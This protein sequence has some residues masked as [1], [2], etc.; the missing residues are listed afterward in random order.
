[1]GI[2]RVLLAIS[3]L[4][5]HSDSIFGVTL[6]NGDM[7]VTC[8][9]M[10]SGFLMALI[11]EQKYGSRSLFYLNRA[12][13]IYP[14]YLA[15]L[16]VSIMVFA[17]IHS[18]RHDPF[19]FVTELWTTGAH[20]GVFIA[21]L[22]NLTLIGADLTRYLSFHHGAVQFPSFLYTVGAGA[23]NLLFV[24]QCWTLAIELE[25][26]LLAPFIVRMSTARIAA[27]ALLSMA[28]RHFAL[29][30]F[31]SNGIRFDGG[32]FFP[33]VL[34]YFLLGVLAYRIYQIYDELPLGRR[35]RIGLEY[36]SVV[37]AILLTYFGRHIRHVVIGGYET[38]YLL[39][40]LQLP[41]LF[42]F[43]KNR[44]W[45]KWLGEYSYPIYLMHFVVAQLLYWSLVANAW[46]GELTLFGTLLLSAAYIYL[47]DRPIQR[48][49]ARIASDAAGTSLSLAKRPIVG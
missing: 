31:H 16:I 9:F 44:R 33:F 21:A 18:H 6:L 12:L 49:R 42:A 1:V 46:V 48:V 24:P 8:F 22:S 32:A 38:F 17:T 4:I 34:Q 11:L 23:H 36:G 40:A 41:L 47:V 27:L 20:T 10:I 7:A 39:F 29:E 19:A 15:A 28:L 5:T 30:W 37:A 35:V 26:Y 3:V 43:S 25:F 45:D 2:I 14:P 13:R